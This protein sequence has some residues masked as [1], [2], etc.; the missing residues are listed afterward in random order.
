LANSNPLFFVYSSQLL[1]DSFIMHLAKSRISAVQG[2]TER[3]GAMLILV[4]VTLVILF[5]GAAFAIDVAYMHTTRA[6]LR[7]A[8]DAASRAGAEALGRTQDRDLA[9]QA[10]IDAAARNQVAGAPLLL[11]ASD[12]LIGTNDRVGS[13]RFTFTEGGLLPDTVQVTGSRLD[14]S[15]SGPV[16]LFFAPMFGVSNF[17]PVMTAASSATTRDI[18]LVLDVSGSMNTSSGGGTRLTALIAAVNT[19]IDEIQ[20]S[21]PNSQMSLSVYSTSAAQ[22]LQLTADLE[23]LRST[24]NAL[25][26]GGYNSIGEGLLTGSDSLVNDPNARPFAS[27]TVVVMTDGN[28]NTGVGPDTAVSTA[29]ARNQTVH[30]ITF[31]SGA[32]QTLMQTVADLGG[33]IHEHADNNAQLDE[34]FREIA[35]TIAVVTI[36]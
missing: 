30:T 32:N 21:S 22:V 1:Q 2:R 18:A 25:T 6:E 9:I 24:V 19:F 11:E 27:K 28:H 8:T 4:L 33:G 31:S 20:A 10:A 12:I 26:A 14:G 36:Q 29:V 35:R 23:S 7:T 16:P 3:R 17:Q 34:A 15:A 13:D 5:V